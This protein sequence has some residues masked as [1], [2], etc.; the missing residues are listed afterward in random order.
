MRPHFLK[1]ALL[2]AAALGALSLAGGGVAHA[3][4]INWNFY[5]VYPSGALTSSA[6]FNSDNANYPMPITATGFTQNRSKTGYTTTNL[7]EKTPQYGTS[8]SGLGLDHFSNNE[9]VPGTFIQLDISNL[10]V[11]PLNQ[12]SMTF[13]SSS[14]TGIDEYQIWGTNTFGGSLNGS[15]SKLNATLLGSGNNQNDI[16]LSKNVLTQDGGQIYQYIDVT[17]TSGNILIHKLDNS[18]PEPGSLVLLGTGLLGLG[19]V[20]RRKRRH[21]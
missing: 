19:L 17:A 3:T 15:L 10:T 16:T 18:V 8:E 2:G 14:T 4:P 13:Q 5:G 1:S 6:T 7:Y 12:L 11:P 20:A 21:A 9:I